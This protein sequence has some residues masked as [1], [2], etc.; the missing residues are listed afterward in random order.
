MG[1]GFL[2]SHPCWYR[3][4][5]DDIKI[6]YNDWPYGIDSHIIHLCVWTKF[7]LPDNPNTGYKTVTPEYHK[8]IDTYVEKTFRKRVPP[9]HVIW[10]KNWG[11]LRSIHSME[12]FHVMLYSPDKDFI[13]EITNDDVPRSQMVWE[14]VDIATAN[15]QTDYLE[16]LESDRKVHLNL[17]LESR[18]TQ[19]SFVTLLHTSPHS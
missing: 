11:S 3:F 16:A 18:H 9:E 15:L 13:K 19:I 7:L 4:H 5:T 17:P 12:H 8:L 2:P 6:I 14:S 10:F 1:L